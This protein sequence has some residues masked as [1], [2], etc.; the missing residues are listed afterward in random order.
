MSIYMYTAEITVRTTLQDR[1]VD[2]SA[3]MVCEHAIFHH[4]K[5]ACVS[6][7]KK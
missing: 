5:G 4:I 1:V 7:V 2:I 6:W 3:L